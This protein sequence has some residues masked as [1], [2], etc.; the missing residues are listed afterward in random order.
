MTRRR[1]CMRI[2]ATAL[3]IAALP[4]TIAHAG[5]RYNLRDLTAGPVVDADDF[6][7]EQRLPPA[8]AR[9]GVPRLH[10]PNLAADPARGR[11]DRDLTV[12]ERDPVRHAR[13]AV[14]L[15]PM[16]PSI[17]SVGQP[18]AF[19]LSANTSGFAHLYVLDA[20]GKVQVWLENVPIE[21]HE[22]LRYPLQGS[23]V[24]ASPP[25]GDETILLV[26]TQQP[27]NGFLGSEESY[28]PFVL[29][30]PRQRFRQ[31]LMAKTSRLRH[32]WGA[33]MLVLRVKDDVLG[34]A[35]PEE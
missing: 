6:V 8:W 4:G 5:E 15:L 11:R 14:S 7:T 33:A 1:S 23:I 9:H 10:F 35:K 27:F 29:P 24:R 20:S 28:R 32:D 18:V 31:A 13:I 21:A 34:Y 19:Q 2:L 17:V 3:V 22:V 12:E 16:T 30:Y 25:G 26:V